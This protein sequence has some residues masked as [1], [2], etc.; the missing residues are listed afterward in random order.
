MMTYLIGEFLFWS[1]IPNHTGNLH[2]LI[3]NP[4]FFKNRNLISIILDEYVIPTKNPDDDRIIA[5]TTKI[6]ANFQ[7][8]YPKKSLKSLGDVLQLAI[9]AKI[10]VL[11]GSTDLVPGS[12]KSLFCK[13]FNNGRCG[14]N[15]GG[16]RKGKCKFIHGCM[17]CGDYFHREPECNKKN[18]L[19]IIPKNKKSSFELVYHTPS[20]R[21]SSNY[22][23]LLHII[24]SSSQPTNLS[25]ISS[26]L[27]S[28]PKTLGYTKFKD[29]VNTCADDGLISLEPVGQNFKIT[30]IEPFIVNFFDGF[31]RFFAALPEAVVEEQPGV[32]VAPDHK[33]YTTVGVKYDPKFK[34]LVDYL[35]SDQ[36]LYSASSFGAVVKKII[37]FFCFTVI[38]RVV[39]FIQSI[40][41]LPC[42]L[43]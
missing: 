25:N 1:I 24:H 22:I 5:P 9:N 3:T 2:L 10:I 6:I 17:K 4:L 27:G 40:N 7:S 14:G 23:E 15:M 39:E 12:E 35:M 32:F 8:L 31:K 29:F 43:T 26:K 34:A 37:Y 42:Q 11:H 18:S 30:I 36:K 20:F 13:D 21:T 28:I 33:T 38:F 41:F 16:E 19:S